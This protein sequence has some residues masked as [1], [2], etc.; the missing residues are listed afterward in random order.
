MSS[1]YDIGLMLL[2]CYFPVSALISINTLN[3]QKEFLEK[4]KISPTIAFFIT[5]MVVALQLYLPYVIITNEGVHSDYS[6]LTVLKQNKWNVLIAL[7]VLSLLFEQQ[8]PIKS[9]EELR[10]LSIKLAYLGG[11]LINSNSF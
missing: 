6:V 3:K 8:Y 2:L 1:N 11:L 7:F 4:R 9:P 10:I 5:L